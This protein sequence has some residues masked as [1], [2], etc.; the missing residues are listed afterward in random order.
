MRFTLWYD[1]ECTQPVLDVLEQVRHAKKKPLGELLVYDLLRDGDRPLL[2]GVYFF[3]SHDGQCLYVGKNS[4]R[5][6]VDRIPVHLCLYPKER[7]NQS[8]NGSSF[9]ARELL[10]VLK[11]HGLGHHRIRPHCPEENGVIERSFR[12]L[13]E[14]LEGEALTNLLEAE[15][16][17]APLVKWY[18]EE[19][20]HSAVGSLPPALVYRGN[21][22]ERKAER[23]RKVAQARHRRREKNLGLHQGTLPLT[24][25]ETVANP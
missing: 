22:E 14:A 1:E 20:L 19:R 4:A 8:D 3:F 12:T 18:N 16:I 11:E 13:R 21:P 9:I 2:W 5:K 6:F 23:R 15:R 24:V 25:G 10:Q 7:M 17:L